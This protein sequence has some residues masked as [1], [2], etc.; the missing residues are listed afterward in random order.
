MSSCAVAE[1]VDEL[2]CRTEALNSKREREILREIER[3]RE[4]RSFRYYHL[5]CVW[6]FDFSFCYVLFWFNAKMLLQMRGEIV[7]LCIIDLLIAINVNSEAKVSLSYCCTGIQYEERTNRKSYWNWIFS[8][9]SY[10]SRVF[11][12]IWKLDKFRSDLNF[13]SKQKR[14]HTIIGEMLKCSD[15]AIG[16]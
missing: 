16:W 4:R 7:H 12:S 13:L 15:S 6:I 11:Y 14:K 2:E 9:Y 1:C 3:S 5:L 8:V 10:R